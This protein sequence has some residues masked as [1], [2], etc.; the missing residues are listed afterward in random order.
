MV[1]EDG[2]EQSPPPTRLCPPRAMPGGLL[3]REAVASLRGF[4]GPRRIRRCSRCRRTVPAIGGRS[5]LKA[6][7]AST[8]RRCARGFARPGR[9]GDVALA[10]AGSRRDAREPARRVRADVDL[11][12]RALVGRAVAAKISTLDDPRWFDV[13]SSS[14]IGSTSTQ[15]V[16]CRHTGAR[17]SLA[18]SA[19]AHSGTPRQWISARAR[20]TS[21]ECRVMNNTACVSSP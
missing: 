4:N 20:P 3:G 7:H 5:R 6:C 2:G 1:R 8:D 16:P 12:F 18:D 19:N 10:A 9:I 17:Y 14:A 15:P 13:R 21:L 11:A